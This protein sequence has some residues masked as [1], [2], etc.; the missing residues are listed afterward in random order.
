MIVFELAIPNIALIG[1]TLAVP[2][3][4]VNTALPLAGASFELLNLVNRRV[5]SMLFLLVMLFFFGKY[6][7]NKFIRFYEHIRDSKYLVGKW[8]EDFSLKKPIFG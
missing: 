5:H 2:Y 8:G 4:V 6:Q 7:V 1:L 3:V